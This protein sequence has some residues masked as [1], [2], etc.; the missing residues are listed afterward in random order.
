MKYAALILTLLLAPSFASAAIARD[1]FGIGTASAVTSH[2]DSI[3]LGASAT[4]LIVF[5]AYST[6]TE[7]TPTWNGTNMT[8]I[9]GLSNFAIT[10]GTYKAS[11]YYI[12]NPTTGT[13]N[14][15]TGTNVSAYQQA[16]WCSYTG[17][18]TTSAVIDNNNHG[19]VTTGASLSSSITVNTANSWVCG[20]GLNNAGPAP[21]TATGVM[22]KLTSNGNM[23]SILMDSA[24]AQT[25]GSKSYGFSGGNAGGSSQVMAVSIAPAS[26]VTLQQSIIGLVHA[27]WVW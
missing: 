17:T 23:T 24:G 25:T 20:L 13:A 21:T 12:N 19:T 11:A 16:Y 14:L 6:G 27:F 7:S 2:T 3:T 9:A 8:A 1:T 15:V 5:H 22:T 26:A 18:D 10:S 4:V